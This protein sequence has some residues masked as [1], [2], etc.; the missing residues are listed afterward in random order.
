MGMEAILVMWPKQFAYIWLTY[1]KE[2]PY[3]I[4]VQLAKWF[5]RKLCFNILM[6]LQYERP[7]LKGQRPAL[8]FG[9]YL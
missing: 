8:T 7:W 6:G 2:S 4:W 3:E 1:H 9:T 5:L